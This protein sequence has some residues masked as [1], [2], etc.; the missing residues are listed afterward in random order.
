MKQ[1][2]FMP[3]AVGARVDKNMISCVDDG[4][5]ASTLGVC[6][7]WEISSINGNPCANTMTTDDVLSLWVAALNSKN[8]YIIEFEEM[9]TK[10]Q[11][12]SKHDLNEFETTT[13]RYLCD[14]CGINNFSKG[15]KMYRCEA[16]TWDVCKNCY[17]N[18]L[19]SFFIW[20]AKNE[21]NWLVT[22]LNINLTYLPKPLTKQIVGYCMEPLSRLQKKLP[23]NC[24]YWS[25]EKCNITDRECISLSSWITTNTSLTDLD[26][27]NNKIG[28]TGA[29]AI[30]T[31]LT[32]NS[33]LII[34][35]LWY[36]MIGDDGAVALGCSLKN[37]NSL[38]RLHLEGNKIG[39]IGV[40]TIA[41]ALHKNS[42]L[43]R[44]RVDR[45]NVGDLGAEA[46]ANALKHNSSLNHINLERN[47]ITDIGA[48][49]IADAVLSNTT[50]TKLSLFKNKLSDISGVKFLT[51]IRKQ[52]SLT[53]LSLAGNTF[54][55]DT[56]NILR[57]AR[58]KNK[59]LMNFS[60]DQD[61]E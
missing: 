16:C 15:T 20:V 28:D 42:T 44:L 58:R 52:P 50:I 3:G 23:K 27:S 14:N 7:G 41:D 25:L 10:L 11:C 47:C 18:T 4:G 43:K 37:N 22:V 32:T 17:N 49:S 6:V 29:T 30:G 55:E 39:D 45:N 38:I 33:T 12:P 51:V 9:A 31:L 19:V 34:I 8:N 36:N 24:K 59:K 53:Q 1:I 35:Q 2:K 21:Q 61:W 46:L 40:K 57:S 13:E 48:T 56:I 54:S 5:Q 26:L 60:I